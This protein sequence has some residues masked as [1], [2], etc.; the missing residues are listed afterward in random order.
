MKKIFFLYL[1]ALASILNLKAQDDDQSN[2]LPTTMF[3]VESGYHFNSLNGKSAI[4]F[5][6]YVWFLRKNSVGTEFHFYLPSVER[7]YNDYQMDFNF[8]RILVDFHPLTFDFLIGPAFRS[9]R[10]SIN[11]DGEFTG[12]LPENERYFAFD[13]IN[14][15]FGVGYRWGNHSIYGMPK[16]N[17]KNAEIQL[18]LGYKFHFDITPI[19]VFDNKYKLK[20]K[21][22]KS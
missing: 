3:S 22:R 14:L 13:G 9:T 7:N 17:H 20:K 6:S 15:G 19:D 8:R 11:T 1:L 10:D 4:G 21:R 2:L 16:I 18:S 12:K 5:K